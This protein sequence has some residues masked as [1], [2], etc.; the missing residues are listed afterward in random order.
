[1][2]LIRWRSRWDISTFYSLEPLLK[3]QII[4]S[5]QAEKYLLLPP[6][7][8]SHLLPPPH[9]HVSHFL[10]A[11]FASCLRL[12]WRLYPRRRA[13]LL[14]L[15]GRETRR[16]HH[17]RSQ[18]AKA[19]NVRSFLWQMEVLLDTGK[20][21]AGQLYLSLFVCLIHLQTI[22]LLSCRGLTVWFRAVDF[23][24]ARPLWFITSLS[25]FCP[26]CCRS[27]MD[28]EAAFTETNTQRQRWPEIYGSLSLSPLGSKSSG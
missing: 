15:H 19:D 12:I 5:S 27:V 2:K 18:K 6:G 24:A 3:L 25:F 9:W 13:S 20:V 21:R 23:R 14:L 10:P 11:S 4:S 16:L 17:V 1:M 7:S 26:I 8:S 22:P 28:L